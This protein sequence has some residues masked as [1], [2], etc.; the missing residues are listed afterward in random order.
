MS[1]LLCLAC[2]HVFGVYSCFLPGL[3]TM[4]EEHSNQ[5]DHVL[6]SQARLVGTQLELFLVLFFVVFVVVWVIIFETLRNKVLTLYPK[7]A[8]SCLCL[9]KVLILQ[10]CTIMPSS[11]ESI[12]S[13]ASFKC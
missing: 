4:V 7:L 1:N 13:I 12:C 9:P 2:Q 11:L 5:E 6:C 3:N 8:I 10:A